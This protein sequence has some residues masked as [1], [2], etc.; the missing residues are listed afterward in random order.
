MVTGLIGRSKAERMLRDL[1]SAYRMV[2]LTGP[3]GIGKTTLAL[4]VARDLLSGFGHGGWIVELASLS[5]PTLVP[6][7]VASVLG[8]TFSG[9][10]ITAEAVARAVS[11]RNLLLILDNCEQVI[12][13]VANLAEMLVRLCPEITILATSQE[14]LRIDGEFVYRVPA[15]EVPVA[16]AADP[17]RILDYSAVELFI[18]RTKALNS[19]FVPRAE[20]LPAVAAICRHLDGIPLAIEF[21]AARAAT[22]GVHRVA[23]GLRD[24]FTLLTGGRRTA[25]PRHR[26]LRATLDWSYQ[27]L[28]KAEQFLLRHLSVFA[29]AFALDAAT[30]IISSANSA[31]PIVETIANLVARSLVVF[32]AAATPKSWRLLETIRAYALE[33]LAESG[34]I[35]AARQRH[36]AYFR[37]LF[38]PAA[39]S[40]S[41]L[42][43]NELMLRVAEIDNVRAAL[44]WAASPAGDKEILVDLTAG[45][46]PVWLHSSLVTECRERCERALLALHDDGD[47]N[48]RRQMQ[49]HAALGS[50]L[51]G[52]MGP[53][54]QT[55]TV[56]NKALEAAENVGDVDVQARVLLSLAGVLVFRGEYGEAT[57]AVERFRQVAHRVGDPAMIVVADRR[58]GQTLF[59]LGR[60]A[61]AQE[62]LERVLRH[63]VPSAGQ[64]D[65]VLYQSDDRAMARAM[66][67]RVLCLRGFT[68]RAHDEAQASLDEL[69]GTAHQLSYCRILYFG[70]CRT[71]LITGDL[72][73]AEWAISRLSKVAASSKAH[74]WQVVGRFLQGKLLVARGEFEKGTAA[75]REAFDTCRRTGWRASYPEFMG[76]LAEGLAGL[77][78]PGDALDAV[79]D[80]V[81]SAGQGADGQVWYVPEL[82]RMK[83]ELLLRQADD[84]SAEDCFDQAREMAREQGALLWEL[85]VANSVA[86]LRIKQ[87]RHDEARKILAPVYDRFS[88]GF[89]IADLRAARAMLD[90]LPS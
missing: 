84:Q 12:D 4:E 26:T 38:A 61:E 11:G 48:T 76:A 67:A 28:P 25:L 79:N 49:L 36:A 51:L 23:T 22:L 89:A 63:S 68:E 70:M 62:S 40:R 29:G 87:G 90:E 85:R 6:A 21:A 7:A 35:D 58:M 78:R 74:F 18:A 60:L 3:G 47:S 72:A 31:T 37:A 44:D 27:L 30:A 19:D 54:E 9:E 81:A 1:V 17:D 73:T 77:G 41:R 20:E 34:E 69:Q 57:G 24:R 43:H 45:Y 33:K 55:K 83:G 32:D 86:R 82:L 5:D 53:A 16:E 15:L 59:T 66:L 10:D 42:P 50:A 75:L 52:T 14:V 64:R 88:E 2:T 8:L 71:A 56:L 46:G 65:T 13:A 80:A 39:G